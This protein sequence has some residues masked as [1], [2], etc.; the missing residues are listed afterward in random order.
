[1]LDVRT[2][3]TPTR[4]SLTVELKTLA[5]TPGILPFLVKLG[6]STFTHTLKFG[7]V[8]TKTG[9]KPSL[10]SALVKRG[11]G[12]ATTKEITFTVRTNGSLLQV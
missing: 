8:I 12:N 2:T 6:K 1:V 9:V 11:K 4:N 7:C 3:I 5:R 10:N